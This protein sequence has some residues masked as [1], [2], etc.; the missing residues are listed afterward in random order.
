MLERSTH[1]FRENL[2]KEPAVWWVTTKVIGA[3]L[4]QTLP[5]ARRLLL[6]NLVRSIILNGQLLRYPPIMH[7][8][9]FHAPHFSSMPPSFKGVPLTWWQPHVRLSIPNLLRHRPPTTQLH[10]ADEVPTPPKMRYMTSK[11]RSNL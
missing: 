9:I 7:D 6:A 3:F 10:T 5:Y 1:S 2:R 11:M 8:S 4:Y